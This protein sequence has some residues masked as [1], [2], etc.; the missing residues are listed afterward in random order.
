M[1]TFASPS[2]QTKKAVA[3]TSGGRRPT[4]ASATAGTE[5]SRRETVERR[6]EAV[7]QFAG[8]AES[9]GQ[10]RELSHHGPSMFEQRLPLRSQRDRGRQRLPHPGKP[11][12]GSTI[13]LAADPLALRFRGGDEA[14]PGGLEVRQ[15]TSGRR[16][17]PGVAEGELGGGRDAIGQDRIDGPSFVAHQDADFEA[18]RPQWDGGAPRP[19]GRKLDRSAVVVDVRARLLEPIA[20]DQGRVVEC[21]GEAVS[22]RGRL[23]AIPEID[24]QAGQRVA[25]PSAPAQID[26]EPSRAQ[27]QHRRRYDPRRREVDR[28]SG[29]TGGD[30]GEAQGQRGRH[31]G[32]PNATAPQWA[33]GCGRAD[34][35]GHRGG[36]KERGLDP[37]RPRG[38]AMNGEQIAHRDDRALDRTLEPAGRVGHEEVRE[39]AQVRAARH[40]CQCSGEPRKTGRELEVGDAPGRRDAR[41]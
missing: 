9:I 40:W 28:S 35:G 24:H 38:E 18:G 29:H 8:R 6:P 10:L 25:R 11:S 31:D 21:S 34:R 1:A 4:G 41:G 30:Q 32:C 39:E 23:S 22:Q 16:M 17:K 26:G 13:E 3:S 36:R 33:S 7:R 20:D 12:H 15:L 19:G 5:D 27:D 14:L 37:V 2:E